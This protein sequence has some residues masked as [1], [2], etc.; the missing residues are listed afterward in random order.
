M[1]QNAA[2]THLLGTYPS[3]P[4]HAA[5]QKRSEV[6]LLLGFALITHQSSCRLVL[7]KPLALTETPKTAK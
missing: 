2:L 4:V 7:C 1:L 5:V 6:P 3:V